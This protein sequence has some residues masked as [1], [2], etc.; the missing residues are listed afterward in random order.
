[1]FYEN[2]P[3]LDSWWMCATTSGLIRK[4]CVCWK[5]EPTLYP[6][7]TMCASHSAEK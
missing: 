4:A 6:T 5:V 2:D 3:M 7:L 1:M